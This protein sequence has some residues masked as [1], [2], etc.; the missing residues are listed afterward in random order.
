MGRGCGFRVRAVSGDIMP[1]D[2]S[3]AILM[4]LAGTFDSQPYAFAAL[5]SAVQA[6]GLSVDL[7]D[8]D[9]I[10]EAPH[11]RLAH[12]FRPGIVGRLQNMQGEDN[13]LIVVRPSVLQAERLFRSEKN[14]L[15]LLGMFAG[16]IIDARD[17]DDLL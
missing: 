9:V 6:Q 3:R 2:K 10:R 16:E 14:G 7:G 17:P 13:T 5:L 1:Q 4:V 12:Y 15:R 11:V 8:V